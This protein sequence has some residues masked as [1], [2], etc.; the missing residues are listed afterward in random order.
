MGP[1]VTFQNQIKDLWGGKESESGVVDK[2]NALMKKNKYVNA[3][4]SKKMLFTQEDMWNKYTIGFGGEKFVLTNP[5][6]Y[7]RLI[8][9]MNKKLTRLEGF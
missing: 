2:L 9:L 4:S 1:S 5:D 8:K 3:L 7:A 6:D